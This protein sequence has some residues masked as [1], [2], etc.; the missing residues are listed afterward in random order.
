MGLAAW[1]AIAAAQQHA[2]LAALSPDTTSFEFLDPATAREVVAIA[3]QIVPSDDGPG[4]TEAGVVYFI[5]R[6]LKTF[7]SD[8]AASFREGIADLGVRRKKM[9]PGSKSFA[10]LT[11][12]Q[13]TELLKSMEKTPFFDWMRTATILAWL[14]P[15]E[16]G[17]NRNQVGWKY[18]GFDDAGFFE[19]PFGYYDKESK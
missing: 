10:A 1:T 8:A 16:Y 14:G 3:A 17:G 6:A 13:Q 7:A 5:D 11:R 18:I 15:P 2:H 19:P 9:F 12:E 4:A